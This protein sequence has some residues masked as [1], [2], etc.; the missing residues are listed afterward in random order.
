MSK[1]RGF[2][3]VELIVVMVLMGILAASFTVFF[4]PAV[5]AFFDARRRADMTDAADTALRKITQ[6]IR[7]AVP[8]SLNLIDGTTTDGNAACLQIVPTIGGG[9]YRT[10]IDLADAAAVA[11]NKDSSAPFKMSILSSQGTSAAQDHFVVINNQNGDDVYDLAPPSVPPAPSRAKISP[12]GPPLTLDKNPTES[13][14]MGGRFQLVSNLETAVMYTCANNTLTRKTLTDFTKKIACETDGA[15][16]AGNVAGCTFTY[17][18]AGATNGLLTMTLVLAH[19][20]SGE[21]ITLGY[22]VHVDNA[23]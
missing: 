4:K 13:G 12:L 21:S 11:L 17:D 8:N 9:R 22:A 15:L 20:A 16:V 1:I 19:S 14:Y 5:D 2:T 18:D 10:N 3:L 23:P 7:R 6:D